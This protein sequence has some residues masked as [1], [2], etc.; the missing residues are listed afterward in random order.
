[1]K[2]SNFKNY[3]EN[4]CIMIVCI[5]YHR[6]ALNRTIL[7]SSWDKFVFLYSYKA[8]NAGGKVIKV[9]P[10]NTTKMCS[11]CGVLVVKGLEE[12]VHSCS[13]G[14]VLDRDLNASINILRLG[15]KSL[16]S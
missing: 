9:N 5:K 3:F 7:D 13:C 8:A 12:R 4:S 11:R 14:L 10:K 16:A 6:H 1:M 2:V 15:Q